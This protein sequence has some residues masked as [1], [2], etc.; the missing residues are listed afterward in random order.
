MNAS[1]QIIPATI[2][3]L[4]G[5]TLMSAVPLSLSEVAYDGGTQLRIIGTAGN[6]AITVKQTAAG[7][8]VGNTGGWTKTVADPISF[9]WINGEAGNNSIIIDSSVSVDA[10]IFAGTGKNFVQ[11]G[12]GNETLVSIGSTADTLVGG[13]GRDSFWTDNSTA[14][15]IQN[16]TAT[17]ISGG[18]VHRVGSYYNA[19][20]ATAKKVSKAKAAATPAAI[21]EPAVD[22]GVTYANFSNDPIFSS[23]GP[24]AND[25]FQ[26]QDGDCY[27]LA[28][29][30]STAKVDPW[31]IRESILDLGDGTAIV[32]LEKNGKEVYV[33]ETEELATSGGSL[34]YAGLGAQNS[35]WVALMEKAWCYVRTNVASYDS[36]NS[37]W[38]DEAYAALGANATSTY[39]AAGPTALL[40]LI[41]KDLS[42]GQSVTYATDAN[43]MPSDSGLLSGHAYEVDSIGLDAS[44]KPITLT[45]RNPWGVDADGTGNGYVTISAAQA[46]AAFT[47]IVAASV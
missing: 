42:A 10:T 17:E 28:V 38:M 35:T 8:V 21:T 13:S 12:S 16:L 45:L 23:T 31:R 18:D 41:A 44:G 5:R 25:V 29:L 32:Q 24:S 40:T 30:S 26:G 37:G 4:E 43:S 36:I 3:N 11:A 7:L 6:D 39:T 47:G 20:P 9:L 27:Y 1:K 34:Y 14:E 15:K 22:A 33:H 46:Y 2:E 19:A